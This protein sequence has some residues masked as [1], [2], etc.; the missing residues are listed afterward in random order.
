M[1][2]HDQKASVGYFKDSGQHTLA[3]MNYS[4]LAYIHEFPEL[5]RHEYRP[6][7][8]QIKPF[9]GDSINRKFL[10][11]LLQDYIKLGS[12]YQTEDVLT[13]I[14]RRYMQKG[15]FIFGN[16]SFLVVTNNPTPL[17][18]TGELSD[19]FGYRTSI[20]YTLRYA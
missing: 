11:T 16:T 20:D 7:I 18:D 3:N 4:T 13:S 14:G 2:L 19:N 15:K 8:G 5:G 10:K 1:R 12:T 6:V 17:Y 9:K